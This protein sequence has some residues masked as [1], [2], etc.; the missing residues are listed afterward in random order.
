MFDNGIL[1]EQTVTLTEACR[2]IPGRPHISTVWRWHHRGCRGIR[3][4]TAVIGGRR[5][6]SREAIVRFIERTTESRDGVTSTPT[7]SRN[8]QA[9]IKAAEQELAEAGI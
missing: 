1:S 9:A 7:P 8:R 4:E 3:L 6:T 5:F 2:I